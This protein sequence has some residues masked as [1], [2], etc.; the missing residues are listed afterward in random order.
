MLQIGAGGSGSTVRRVMVR[1]LA[2]ASD[3]VERIGTRRILLQG[4]APGP[5]CVGRKRFVYGSQQIAGRR[6]NPFPRTRRAL[7]T[8]ND[9]MSG[10][11][12][13]QAMGGYQTTSPSASTS[14]K[15]CAGAPDTTRTY[16]RDCPSINCGPPQPLHSAIR[17]PICASLRRPPLPGIRGGGETIL[18][19]A[20]DNAPSSGMLEK[21]PSQ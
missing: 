9:R 2:Q 21:N 11:R 15:S 7:L 14:R 12:K 17:T 13:R 4:H 19:A 6:E 20:T 5:R 10:C 8:H 1:C 3:S 16:R 18:A